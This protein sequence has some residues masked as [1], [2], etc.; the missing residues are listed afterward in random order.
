MGIIKKIFSWNDRKIN[1]KAEV[2]INSAQRK[3][4]NG[5]Y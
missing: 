1:E 4:V 2:N 3:I 5:K